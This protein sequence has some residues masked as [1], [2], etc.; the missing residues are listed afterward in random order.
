MWNSTIGEINKEAGNW[1]LLP[2]YIVYISLIDYNWCQ[3][4]PEDSYNEMVLKRG[5]GLLS[6]EEPWIVKLDAFG[7]LQFFAKM[8][9]AWLQVTIINSEIIHIKSF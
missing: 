5:Y 1:W 9:H 6:V 7:L 8:V 4:L 3:S 2:C